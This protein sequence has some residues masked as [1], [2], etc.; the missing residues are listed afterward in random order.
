[1]STE[2][3]FENA[4]EK[5]GGQA[6]EGLGKLSGDKELETEG[7]VDQTKAGLKDTLQDAKDSVTGALK[8]LKND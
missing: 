5:L 6:K 7:Q 3:K 1:M 2:D 8:G 4:G